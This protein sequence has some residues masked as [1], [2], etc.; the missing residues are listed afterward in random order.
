[1]TLRSPSGKKYAVNMKPTN[2]T[3]WITEHTEQ[4]NGFTRYW[5][6]LRRPHRKSSATTSAVPSSRSTDPSHPLT[7]Q[8]WKASCDLGQTSA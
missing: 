6:R 7:K 8:S 3:H 5:H 1:M 4:G 2:G